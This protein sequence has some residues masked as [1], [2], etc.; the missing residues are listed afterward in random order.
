MGYNPFKPHMSFS[1]AAGAGVG[2]NVPPLPS[3][4]PSTPHTPGARTPP[5]LPSASSSSSITAAPANGAL[6]TVEAVLRSGNTFG[7]SA[8]EYDDFVAAMVS[9]V[10]DSFAM[11]LSLGKN[12]HHLQALP[13]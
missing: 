9:L 3:S 5:P 1:G 2:T 12:N 4:Q 6:P 10:D 7:L 8:D 13:G 11:L